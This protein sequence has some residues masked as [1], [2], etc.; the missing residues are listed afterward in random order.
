MALLHELYSPLEIQL[1]IAENAKN[2]RLQKNWSRATL[3][4][5]SGVPASSIKVFETT[6]KVSLQSLV[7]IAIALGAHQPLLSLFAAQPPV[8]FEDITVHERK[9]GRQ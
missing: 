8:R 3:A 2:L 1:K 6:G 4:A 9:R 5:R 7:L